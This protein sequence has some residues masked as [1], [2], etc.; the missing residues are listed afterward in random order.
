MNFK[1]FWTYPLLFGILGAL[2]GLILRYAYTGAIN[3]F[4]FKNV[5]HSHSHVM[6]LG[7]V[8]NGLLVI[9]WSNFTS[10]IDKITFRL[11]LMLQ[12]CIALF[13]VAF[14]LQGYAL[15]SILFS[16]THLW[17]SYILLIRLWKQV[18]EDNPQH[19]LIRLGIIFHFLSS[20][21]PYML[22]SLMAMEMQTSP[23]YQQAIFF[24]LH[25][26]YFGVFFVWMLAVLFKK[27]EISLTKKESIALA[28]SLIFLF[29]H[30][31]D[32][33]FNHWSIQFFGSI[34]SVGLFLLLL[35][36][37]K[38]FNVL[39]NGYKL[40][41][42]GVL[43][44][45]FFNIIGSV[46]PIANLLVESRFIL[47]AWLHL[48]FLGIYT[49]F[50]WLSLSKKV[51]PL[52]WWLYGLALFSSEIAL[53]FPKAIT[54]FISIPI[55]WFLFVSYLGIFLCICWVHITNLLNFGRKKV[56]K[57]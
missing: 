51:H 17:I 15:F 1:K 42:L 56:I 7:F 13:S 24:Y 5:L 27:V 23:W 20:L 22:G 9:V 44:I 19:K 33:S 2:L 36:F 48:L 29:A 54:N 6:L 39:N 46:P 40:I 32:F 57:R 37:V 49:P 18:S 12:L 52:V 35:N 38:R 8:F 21:G 16:T 53:V 34:G 43:I 25:F 26:Q 50:I 4:P 55:L 14:V 45:A 28:V 31:L 47:I 41:Y 11:F 3:G 30:S 10:H